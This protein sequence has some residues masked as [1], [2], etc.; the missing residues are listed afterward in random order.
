MISKSQRIAAE[1]PSFYFCGIIYNLRRIHPRYLLSKSI[2]KI[3]PK[4]DYKLD[5]THRDWLL[6]LR[7]SNDSLLGS[8]NGNEA[9][10][11][12]V[13]TRGFKLQ[14]VDVGEFDNLEINKD[15]TD[16]QYVF[17]L[18]RIECIKIK[19][20]SNPALQ[21]NI[22]NCSKCKNTGNSLDK[23][24]RLLKEPLLW[25]TRGKY[26]SNISNTQSGKRIV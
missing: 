13:S 4:L 17:S 14:S 8:S 12:A 18:S 21:T 1:I 20:G 10:G 19:L 5:K 15:E 16:T 3:E 7:M 24:F 6:R 25:R 2:K 22:R 9:A 11:L 26:E 23:T